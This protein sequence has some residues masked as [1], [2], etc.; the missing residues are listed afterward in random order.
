[1]NTEDVKQALKGAFKDASLE[2]KT[3]GGNNQMKVTTSYRVSDNSP[4]VDTEVE[5][6]LNDGL[7]TLNV[8]HEL[9]S[10]QKV[11]PTIATDILYGAY[12]AILFSCLVMFIYIVVRFK[13]W[14]Y[15]L[16]AVVAL[17]HDVLMVLSFYTILDGVVPFSLEIGQ[18]FIA[19]ILTVMG[20]TMTE[21]VV[22]FDRIRERLA[23]HVNADATN[24]ERNT[25]INYAL[26]STLSRTILTSLTVFFVL[27]VI[28][29]FGGESIRGFI[30][31]LL[32]GRI[33]GTY[34]SLCISTPIVVDFD[35]KKD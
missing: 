29:I 21:T 27:L 2:V 3:V 28:F 35:K 6:A 14:Q 10:Q 26:N 8:K 15:G 7:N 19:A 5:N 31:A 33:I 25:L 20:Y 18:D 34:S 30:F 22:V 16:G 23:E 17:F 32:I 1:M 11:G 13:K 24:A 9:V 4:T 12:A